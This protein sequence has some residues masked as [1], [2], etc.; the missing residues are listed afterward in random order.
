M[1]GQLLERE[2]SLLI[3]PPLQFIADTRGERDVA[4]MDPF[5]TEKVSEHRNAEPRILHAGGEGSVAQNRKLVVGPGVGV[6]DVP[7]AEQEIGRER[8]D[9]AQVL[10]IRQ[11]PAAADSETRPDSPEIVRDVF[12]RA[13]AQGGNDGIGTSRNSNA[14][15]AG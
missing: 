11:A 2:H 6:V 9:E 13:Q 15:L 4:L 12:L 7:L 10:A 8:T 14:R 5:E 3:G 1:H